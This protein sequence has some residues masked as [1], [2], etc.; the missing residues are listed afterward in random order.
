MIGLHYGKCKILCF[1]V[2]LILEVNGF[3]AVSAALFVRLK[4]Q[5]VGFSDI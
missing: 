3:T 2:Q 5:C 1:S 4:V